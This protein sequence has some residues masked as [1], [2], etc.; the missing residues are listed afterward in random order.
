MCDQYNNVIARETGIWNSFD[1]IRY[2]KNK[3]LKRKHSVKLP[4]E[5]KR[6]NVEMLKC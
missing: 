6:V 3:W 5:G 2:S 1:E 4:R